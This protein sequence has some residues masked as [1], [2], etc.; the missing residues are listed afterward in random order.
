MKTLTLLL[1][2]AAFTAAGQCNY[3]RNEIDPFTGTSIIHLET[4]TMHNYNHRV[5]FTWIRVDD[6]PMLQISIVTVAD[7]CFTDPVRIILLDENGPIELEA[8]TADINCG[9]IVSGN[10]KVFFFYVLAEKHME[11]WRPIGI[12]IY[13]HERN[14][15]IERF[16]GPGTRGAMDY[17]RK[18]N[19]VL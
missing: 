11:H 15:T 3:A 8:K 19:C 4:Q 5:T 13:G 18:V 10:H 9:E 12:R 14:F 6:L 7:I 2:L 16:R 1:L 17:M